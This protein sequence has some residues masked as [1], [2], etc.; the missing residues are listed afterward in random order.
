MRYPHG[1]NDKKVDYCRDTQNEELARRTKD[2]HLQELI[3][4][5]D[6]SVGLLIWKPDSVKFIVNQI[7]I[8]V[9]NKQIWY[10]R[11]SKL[12][13]D[14]IGTSQAC[15]LYAT[16][17]LHINTTPLKHLRVYFFYV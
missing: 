5:L 12:F 4:F 9:H 7:K 8:Y 16:E 17:A 6:V 1:N 15:A 14:M 3:F 10:I 11:H 2:W 13:I